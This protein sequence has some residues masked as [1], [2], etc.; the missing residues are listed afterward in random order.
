[1]TPDQAKSAFNW[2]LKFCGVLFLLGVLVG[3]GCGAAQ[4]AWSA[5]QMMG[6]GAMWGGLFGIIGSVLGFFFGANEVH[7]G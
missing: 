2:A 3:T 7:L 4:S 6:A 5:K 1:M